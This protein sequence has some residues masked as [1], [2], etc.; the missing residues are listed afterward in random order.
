MRPPRVHIKLFQE[1]VAFILSPCWSAV[2]P[3]M[4]HVNL[5]QPPVELVQVATMWPSLSTPELGPKAALARAKAVRRVIENHILN[6]PCSE[7][8]LEAWSNVIWLGAFAPPRRRFR[9]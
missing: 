6:Y 1:E 7:A 9:R 3:V 5:L 4:S 2:L 8:M